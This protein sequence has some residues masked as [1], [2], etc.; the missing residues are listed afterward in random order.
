MDY[1]ERISRSMRRN[2]RNRSTNKQHETIDFHDVDALYYRKWLW[3]IPKNLRKALRLNK[4]IFIDE[5]GNIMP[6]NEFNETNGT[7]F[8]LEQIYGEGYW[9]YLK[10]LSEKEHAES[11]GEDLAYDASEGLA[12]ALLYLSFWQDLDSYH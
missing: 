4:T 3:G 7:H 11:G 10:K 1:R 2:N 6:L 9:G 5:K 8:T 12:D